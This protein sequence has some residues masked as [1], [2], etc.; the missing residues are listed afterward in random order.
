MG[1][2]RPEKKKVFNLPWQESKPCLVKKLQLPFPACLSH[3]SSP[4]AVQINA[5]LQKGAQGMT[6]NNLFCEG[7]RGSGQ[8]WNWACIWCG[9]HEP[10]DIYIWLWGFILKQVAAFPAALAMVP[11]RS[12]G[13]NGSHGGQAA[14]R[15][16]PWDS[17]PL[18]AQ[19]KAEDGSYCRTEASEQQFP[20][21]RQEDWQCRCPW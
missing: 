5:A 14:P 4:D 1:W 18:G 20:S 21:Y 9:R 2:K 7:R 10:H 3:V 16:P 8:P 15:T 11:G 12:W 6:W 13:Q 17:S 19:H